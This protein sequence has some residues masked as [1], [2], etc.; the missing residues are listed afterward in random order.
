MGLSD[1]V[2]GRQIENVE[3]HPCDL[4]QQPFAVL[5]RSVFAAFAERAGEQLVPGA[6]HRLRSVYGDGQF[7]VVQSGQRAVRVL[8][9]QRRQFLAQRRLNC[10]ARTS[11]RTP[12][13]GPLPELLGVG[14]FGP[15][16]G[17]GEQLGA[18]LQ[19]DSNVLIRLDPFDQIRL[20][21]GERVHPCTNRIE[22]VAQLGD[23][24]SR[25]P[26]VVDAMDHRLNGPGIL[27]GAAVQQFDANAIVSVGE[28]VSL[29]GHDFAERPL[30]RKASPV[31][32]RTHVVDCRALSAVVVHN[33]SLAASL[34]SVVHVGRIAPRREEK[35][36]ADAHPRG[37]IQIPRTKRCLCSHDPWSCRTSL[38]RPHRLCAS[39]EDGAA[40]CKPFCR[41]GYAGRTNVTEHKVR[42][43][44]MELMR[45]AVRGRAK[46]GLCGCRLP[47]TLRQSKKGG[48]GSPT[49]SSRWY[50]SASTR[51]SM[52]ASGTIHVIPEVVDNGRP[53]LYSYRRLILDVR[54]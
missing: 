45:N 30:D 42:R 41:R 24:K 10:R 2:N 40:E 13:P 39:I 9:H 6:E 16:R 36:V 15:L 27:P 23:G 17:S 38:I 32:L 52:D 50:G 46:W 4:R 14:F 20:P 51:T 31:D 5:E 25:D 22:I 33:H 28:D 3:P 34:T 11:G 53:S 29:D 12:T 35:A 18:D 43:R 47:W 8:G 44:D 1:G 26:F 19:F 37:G 21:R 48:A 54:P 49:M 7:P